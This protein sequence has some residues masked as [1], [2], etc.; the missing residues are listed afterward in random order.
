MGAERR[1]RAFDSATEARAAYASRRLFSR[2]TDEAL[3]SYVRH[4]FRDVDGAWTLKCAP[5]V[6]AEFYRTATA[7]GAWDRLA[8]VRCPAV[9]V[10]G[11]D[12]DSHPVSFVEDQARRLGDGSMEIVDEAS[13]LV[14]MERPAQ[15]AEIIASI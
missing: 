15:L 2:W 3:D 12:S 14:P 1:R 6:E 9:V 10:A 4:G 5:E 13:H 8:E 11:R 7:H